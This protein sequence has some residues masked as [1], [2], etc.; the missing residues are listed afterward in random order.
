LKLLSLARSF[1][2]ATHLRRPPFSTPALVGRAAPPLL[3]FTSTVSSPSAT[4]TLAVRFTFDP[5][6]GDL[7]YDATGTGV[8]A[9]GVL[10]A[11]IQRGEE[12]Q[13][14]AALFQV[15]AIGELRRSGAFQLSPTFHTALVDGKLDLVFYWRGDSAR[16]SIRPK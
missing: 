12:K 3:Q 15:L 6:T 9:E 16:T 5:L 13:R 2:E 11:W 14:G 10:G 1:E 8:K 4:A 7:R